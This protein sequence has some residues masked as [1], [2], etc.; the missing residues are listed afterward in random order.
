[1]PNR[2]KNRPV[3]IQTENVRIVSSQPPILPSS[4]RRSSRR[5]RANRNT[6]A[7]QPVALG[8]NTG[9]SPPE[10]IPKPQRVRRRPPG[11]M[12]VLSARGHKLSEHA[13]AW[14]AKIVDPC[15]EHRFALDYAKVPDGAVPQSGCPEFRFLDTIELPFQT[16]GNVLLEGATYSALFLTIPL[17]RSLAFLIVNKNDREFDSVLMTAFC[18]VFNQVGDQSEFTYPSFIPVPLSTDVDGEITTW[19]TCFDTLSLRAIDPPNKLGSSS[20]ITNFRYTSYGIRVTFNTPTLLDQG[21]FASLRFPTNES[22]QAWEAPDLLGFEPFYLHGVV[23]AGVEIQLSPSH[24]A[25]G[26][27]VVVTAPSTPV[28]LANPIR[29]Q[30]NSFSALPTDTVVIQLTGG[31]WQLTNVT[32]S[33]SLV[34]S[35]DHQNAVFTQRLYFNVDTLDEGSEVSS[36]RSDITLLSLPPVTQSAIQQADT[37]ATSGKVKDWGG[38][39]LPGM[40][41]QPVFNVSTSIKYGRDR[42]SV[43]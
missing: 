7:N 13:A 16:P 28:T 15:G 30:T 12:Q 38:V 32:T 22:K 3:G 39:Y 43:V 24:P 18:N 34:L 37:S 41:F 17:F 25:L 4:T 40:I 21:T 10:S 19:F 29:N 11:V 36:L 2:R 33:Q 1:M 9:A 42:K 14:V 5:R 27:P 20:T 8:I 23:T 31:T 6:V 26:F 35:L